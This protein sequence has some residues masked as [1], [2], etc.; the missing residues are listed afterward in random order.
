VWE[1]QPAAGITP[2]VLEQPAATKQQ[3]LLLPPLLLPFTSHYAVI[4]L[5]SLTGWRFLVNFL[6]PPPMILTFLLV[7]PFPRNVRKGL[8]IFTNQVLSFTVCECPV[9]RSRAADVHTCGAAA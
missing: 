6:L 7:L 3:Q 8:L 4:C 9:S 1:N 5:L 2:A